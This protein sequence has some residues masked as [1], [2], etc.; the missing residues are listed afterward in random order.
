MEHRFTHSQIVEILRAP[1]AEW[2]KVE[3][4]KVRAQIKGEGVFLRGIIEFS[5]YC[6]RNC[7]YCGL[8]AA[9]GRAVR[10]RL[11]PESILRQALAI[12][13]AGIGTVVLQSGDD[14][15]Y[16]A[17]D[18]VNLVQE[19]KR[20]ANI[21]VV[22]SVGER[23]AGEYTLWRSAGADRYLIKHE[24]ADTD[25]YGALHPG[26]TLEQRLRSQHLLQS[27]GYEIGTGFIVGLPGQTEAILAEDVL[28]VQKMRAD[29]C[30]IGP[31]VPQAQTPLANHPMGSV[32]MT[33]RL[34]SL[35][36]L[37]CPEINLPATTA[38]ATLDSENGQALALRAGANVIMPNF[39]P[40]DARSKYTIYDN[41]FAV[42]L[43]SA[44]DTVK[45]VNRHVIW[46]GG[47]RKDV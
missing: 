27:L 22:L 20:R 26:K 4:D 7:L 47:L 11:P 31:F 12:A 28:L 21:A 10:Y 42:D 5:S 36:R 1:E 16:P 39:T 17:E 13:A 46:D 35:L 9:N 41:K 19:I 38:L 43:E 14:L 30:G 18:I 6:V 8:R 40:G 25:L 23:Q 3:A 33:L 34:I 2:L 32:E 44:L 15:A 24:T 45:R 29:M 37:M